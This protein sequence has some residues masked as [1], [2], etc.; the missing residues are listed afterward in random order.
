MKQVDD[1]DDYYTR[2]CRKIADLKV[3]LKVSAMNFVFSSIVSH[4]YN[5]YPG[6]K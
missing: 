3:N 6:A 4:Q 1:C 5:K 2:V